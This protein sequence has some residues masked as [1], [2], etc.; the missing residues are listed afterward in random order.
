MNHDHHLVDTRENYTAAH[1]VL[2]AEVSNRENEHT[3]TCHL[4]MMF[5]QK[6]ECKVELKKKHHSHSRLL[7]IIIHSTPFCISIIKK[8]WIKMQHSLSKGSYKIMT[9]QE[10][11]VFFS[12]RSCSLKMIFCHYLQTLESFQAFT[13][14]FRDFQC[15]LRSH[16]NGFRRLQI[17]MTFEKCVSLSLCST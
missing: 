2:I 14:F 15:T 9:K 4:V 3:R 8:S 11:D 12:K 17:W 5:T 10:R 16:T 6:M 1:P 13:L 7:K